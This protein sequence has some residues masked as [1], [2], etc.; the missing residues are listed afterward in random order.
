VYNTTSALLALTHLP[1]NL[2]AV[3]KVTL[4]AMT[5]HMNDFT[6]DLRVVSVTLS[7]VVG[8]VTP[9]R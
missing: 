9:F 3:M 8:R 5:L 4:P 2:T 6:I 1:L 7:W